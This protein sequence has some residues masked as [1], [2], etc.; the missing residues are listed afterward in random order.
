M[1]RFAIGAINQV[2]SNQAELHNLFK[3]GTHVGV[4]LKV[5]SFKNQIH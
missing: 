2:L 5:L 1:K 3:L 4:H